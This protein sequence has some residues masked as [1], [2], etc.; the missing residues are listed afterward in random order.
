M[1]DADFWLTAGPFSW[2]EP[3]LPQNIRG[4]V[5]VDDR[6]VISGTMHVLKSG[7]RWADAPS[8]YGSRKTR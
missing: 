6:L 3:N 7:C 4:K 5:R 2:L 8:T 1:S